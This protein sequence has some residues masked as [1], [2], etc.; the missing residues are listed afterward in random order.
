ML[1]QE[2]LARETMPW[3]AVIDHIMNQCEKEDRCNLPQTGLPWTVE[4]ACS[5]IFI[6]PMDNFQGGRYGTQTQTVVAGWRE[7]TVEYREKVLHSVLEQPESLPKLSRFE[8]PLQISR[9]WH[10]APPVETQPF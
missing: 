2:G 9:A 1:E 4:H 8:I 3:Q 5:S 7:G 10:V 6:L